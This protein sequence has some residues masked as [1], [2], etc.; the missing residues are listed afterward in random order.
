MAEVWFKS[1]FLAVV[2]WPSKGPDLI[3]MWW[4]HPDQKFYSPGQKSFVLRGL[5]RYIIILCSEMVTLE[6]F[7]NQIRDL[8]CPQT[9]L[10]CL[11]FSKDE[12][13]K[14]PRDIFWL[15]YKK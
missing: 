8:A 14:K 13:A 9:L 1:T 2:L 7:G 15:L 3:V 6:R 5:K 10:A 11:V 4:L 12:A